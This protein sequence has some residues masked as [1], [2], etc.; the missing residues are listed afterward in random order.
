MMSSI[1]L[2]APGFFLPVN[3][4]GSAFYFFAAAEVGLR[5]PAYSSLY[6]PRKPSCDYS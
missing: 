1:F 6:I 3:H 5:H 2:V 4:V